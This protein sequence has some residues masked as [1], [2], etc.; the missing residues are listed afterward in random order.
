[1]ETATN[2]VFGAEYM[3]EM[4]Q[5]TATKVTFLQQLD[6]RA[7]QDILALQKTSALI[8]GIT[9]AII[10]GI[11]ILQVISLI[12]IRKKVIR[13]IIEIQKEML[14]IAK[15]NL[16]SP[17]DIQPDTS[18][19]GMLVYAIQTTKQNLNDYIG[20]ITSKLQNM[21]NNN[22]DIAITMDYVGDFEPIKTALQTIISSLNSVLSE[23]NFASMQ[24]ASSSE[25]VA[26]GAQSLAQGSTE[27]SS[28]V[29]ELSA[30]II[31]L[32]EHI[33]R[34]AENAKKANQEADS[35][36]SETK[37]SNQ[38]MQEM[39]QA[40][41]LISKK[42]NEISHIIRTIEDIAFQTN[43]LALN[44]AVEAAR[45]GEAGKGFA[46]VADEVRSLASRSAEAAKDTTLLISETI[47]AVENGSKIS[48]DTAER[49][50]N[51]V[52]F[53]NQTISLVDTISEASSQQSDSIEHIR[54]GV[55]QISA[56]VQ[57]NAAT[58]EESAAASQELSSQA[59]IMQEQINKFQLTGHNNY[60]RIEAPEYLGLPQA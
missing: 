47:Q 38:L 1:M 14:E 33:N 43:I 22:M 56:V 24:V 57:A 30:A 39:V 17:F 51:T 59:H 26:G 15:G 37:Q 3:Q 13:P 54:I 27:Q 48:A 46:V 21:A 5:I 8:K 58:S 16:S 41:D 20:D 42:S 7:E 6:G 34:N 44:A 45:A 25:Q 50:E 2:I 53:V 10:F 12:V 55:E 23:I 31:E 18:E 52:A 19:I 28:S 40:M 60:N 35:A 49:M 11:I 29:Q 9:F 4:E 32:S 36:G